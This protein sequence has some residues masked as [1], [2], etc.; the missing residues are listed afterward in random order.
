MIGAAMCVSS[1]VNNLAYYV[2]NM[3]EKIFIAVVRGNT[4]NSKK[5]KEKNS[6][7]SGR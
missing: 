1:E 4:F 2:K 7:K 3:T 6:F 5:A